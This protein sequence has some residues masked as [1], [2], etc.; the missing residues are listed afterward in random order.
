MFQN[1]LDSLPIETAYS[2]IHII[3]KTLTALPALTSVANY[4]AVN[5]LVVA[6]T[7]SVARL[8]LGV[9]S[10]EQAESNKE[11]SESV[12]DACSLY[13][14][15]NAGAFRFFIEQITEILQSESRM[16]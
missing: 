16:C 11:V 10:E 4:T 15:V 9:A 12:V 6:M 13:L 5:H 7:T 8:Q 2:V 14:W 1:E 3:S